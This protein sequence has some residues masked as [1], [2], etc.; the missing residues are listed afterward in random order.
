MSLAPV[1]LSFFTL[2]KWKWLDPHWGLLV[3]FNGSHSLI[4][5]FRILMWYVHG[6]LPVIL[7]LLCSVWL[8]LRLISLPFSLWC[9]PN[10]P[11]WWHRSWQPMVCSQIFSAQSAK[12]WSCQQW[13]PESNGWLRQG[14]WILLLSSSILT[15]INFILPLHHELRWWPLLS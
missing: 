1:F 14:A 12:S 7:L 13:L 2:S 11:W 4:R 15:P 10:Q 8:V 3:Y 5:S 6:L 9:L